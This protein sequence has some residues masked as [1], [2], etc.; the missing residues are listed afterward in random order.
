EVDHQNVPQQHDDVVDFVE[1]L[2]QALHAEFLLLSLRNLETRPRRQSVPPLVRSCGR[3]GLSATGLPPRQMS[4]CLSSV[5]LPP[6]ALFSRCTPPTGAGGRRAPP[7][8]SA[9]DARSGGGA[10][11]IDRT[12][13]SIAIDTVA[14]NT[15]L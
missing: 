6:A 12:K 15:R 4:G 11:V 1:Q 2:H 10:A 9:T 8:A 5:A 14:C 3:R 7:L 13:R